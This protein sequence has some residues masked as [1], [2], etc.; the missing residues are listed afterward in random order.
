MLLSLQEHRGVNQQLQRVPQAAF[1]S[2]GKQW[3]QSGQCVILNIAGHGRFLLV[4]SLKGYA[5]GL[6]AW[7]AAKQTDTDFTETILH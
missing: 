7:Q 4:W 6:S 3:Q 2:V 1:L 5:R